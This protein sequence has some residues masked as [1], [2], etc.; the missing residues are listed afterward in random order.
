V[1]KHKRT[2]RRQGQRSNRAPR[3][4]PLARPN[5]RWSEQD[6]LRK[7]DEVH[8][9]L[10]RAAARPVT[11]SEMGRTKS[12]R[13]PT[14]ESIAETQKRL[15]ILVRGAKGGDIY[16]VTPDFVNRCYFD[17]HRSRHVI[18]VLEE[19][20][21][22]SETGFVYLDRLWPERIGQTTPRTVT[23][24]RETIEASDGVFNAVAIALYGDTL[25]HVEADLLP[26][27]EEVASQW[28]RYHQTQM[29]QTGWLF[30]ALWATLNGT[31]MTQR[32][33]TVA[34]EHTGYR[35]LSV[36]H[37]PA[38]VVLLRRVVDPDPDRER[39]HRSVDWRWRWVVG[40]DTG[41][42]RHKRRSTDH[43]PHRV[44]PDVTNTKCVHCN[45]PITHVAPFTKG[46]QGAPMKPTAQTVY[47]LAR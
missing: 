2:P 45:V 12:G 24:A 25:R 5:E 22:P 19:D 15:T 42:W 16:W 44:L 13:K 34:E 4:S 32:R 31:V 37:G 1:P 30:R 40:G 35:R 28:S 21:L 14:P 29:R 20:M 33:V 38:R 23:W 36:V 26:F 39:G 27:G 3:T 41:F 6:V 46:P 11:A 7:R 10:S 43:A 17:A 8:T 18:P 47:K 9:L